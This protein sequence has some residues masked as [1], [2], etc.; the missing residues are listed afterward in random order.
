MDHFTR[1]YRSRVL[2][3]L[4]TLVAQLMSTK[5]ITI[6]FLLDTTVHLRLFLVCHFVLVSAC[7]QLDIST[8]FALSLLTCVFP[9]L[10]WS[11]PCDLWSVGCILVE[12]CS[13]Y[14]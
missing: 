1:G 6:L 7:V 3:R 10:G 9:G 4:L 14:I 5:T 13:V 11:Y 12:L 8:R 2:L